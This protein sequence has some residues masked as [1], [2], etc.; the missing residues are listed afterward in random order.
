MPGVSRV[1]PLVA[2]LVASAVCLAALA[3]CGESS[4]PSAPNGSSTCTAGDNG[5]TGQAYTIKQVIQSAMT[6]DHLKG[7]IVRVTQNGRNVYT[8]A[9]GDSMFGV[10]VTTDMQFRNGA[11]AF[12]YDSTILL[13]MV[14]QGKLNLDDTVS[15][16]FPDVPNASTVTLKELANMTSGYADYVY[17]PALYTTILGNPFTHWTDAQL[18]QIGFSAPS[19]FGP[20]TNFAYAHTNYILLPEILSK[21]A[22][23]PITQVMQD[24]IF[25]PLHLTNTHTLTTPAMPQPVMH[26]YSAERRG[27]L[28]SSSPYEDSTY[29]DPS[30][31]TA[32]GTVQSQDICDWTTSAAAI[33]TGSLLSAASHRTQITPHPGFGHPQAG[34]QKCTTQTSDLG[35]GLGVNLLGSWVAQSKSFSGSGA[36]F[37]YLPSAKLA[38]SA[39]TTYAPEA[40]DAD[41]GY[42]NASL[43]LF[44]QLGASLVPQDPPPPRVEG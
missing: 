36:T 22:G 15:K 39:V 28:G 41:G 40:F 23:K 16:W 7:L 43:D 12:S 1:H 26:A 9:M 32:E 2:V 6:A 13:K 25:T 17:Q 34:C 35:Y 29:W 3:A 18:K 19:Q 42:A 21:V 37:G 38:I 24:Y 30:W 4:A 27:L 11:M 8:G 31:T 20:G 5:N 10:P 44:R 33:G 14:D